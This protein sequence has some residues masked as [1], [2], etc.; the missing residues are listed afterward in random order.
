MKQETKADYQEWIKEVESKLPESKRAAFRDF[1]SGD[2]GFEVFGGYQREKDYYTR[3]NKL[4]QEKDQLEELENSIANGRKQ[5]EE[6]TNRLQEWYATETSKFKTERSKLSA[7][8]TSLREKLREYGLEDDTT[9]NTPV[10]R[11]SDAELREE[12]QAL[13]QRVQFMDQAVPKVLID[14]LTV[15]KRAVKEDFDVDP[16]SLLN[17]LSQRGG[18][19]MGAFESVTASERQKRADAELKRQLEEARKE[20]ERSALT[21]IGSPDGIRPSGPSVSDFLSN[22]NSKLSREQ[23]LDAAVSTY[24]QAVSDGR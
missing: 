2:E 8:V 12:L 24:H 22:M 9:S 23:R 10:Q 11:S 21:R 3:L 20:G 4:T 14:G 13:K 6:H 1:T 19:L 17:H 5:L 18:D 15:M 7:E 16:G